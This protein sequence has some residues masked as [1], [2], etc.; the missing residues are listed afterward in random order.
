[1][2]FYYTNCTSHRGQCTTNCTPYPVVYL[3]TILLR[4]FDRFTHESLILV[5]RKSGKTDNSTVSICFPVTEE[6]KAQQKQKEKLLSQVFGGF[7]SDFCLFACV[8]NMSFTKCELL[9]YVR[10]HD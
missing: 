5:I 6:K 2:N 10:S 3:S 1:M 4:L 8:R 7:L 9:N